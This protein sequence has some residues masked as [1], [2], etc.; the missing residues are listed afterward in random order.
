[1]PSV[2]PLREALYFG[3]IR[4]FNQLH[5]ILFNGMEARLRSINDDLTVMAPFLSSLLLATILYLPF[6]IIFLTCGR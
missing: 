2:D 3:V 5:E 6:F 4:P 1:M